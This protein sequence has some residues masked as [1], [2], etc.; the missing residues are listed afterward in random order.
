[1]TSL[2]K[3]APASPLKCA[4]AKSKELNSP[5][6]NTYEN[7]RGALPLSSQRARFATQEIRPGGKKIHAQ[8]ALDERGGSARQ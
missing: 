1:M 2:A 4:V 3:K 7:C 5:G 8:G 6:I